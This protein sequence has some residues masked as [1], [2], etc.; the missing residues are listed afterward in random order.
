[1]RAIRVAS[2]ALVALV[3]LAG[4]VG[5]FL[6]RFDYARQDRDNISAAASAQHWLGTD[7]LGRD[8]FSRLL[9]GTRV[10][11]LLAPAAAALSILLALAIG[12]ATGWVGG[13]PER[14]SKT[15]IDLFL[16]VPWLFLLLMVRA[17]LPLNT[18]P[19]VSA[20]VTF[21]VLGA[22][23]WAAPGRILQAR[24]SRLRQ[25]QFILL[26]RAAGLSRWRLLY[27]HVA[28]NL[29]PVLLAQFWVSV[30]VFILAEANLS[31]LGLG[32]AEPLPSLGSMLRELESVL[33]L[34]GG[35]YRFAALM[36]L[37]VVVSSLQIAVSQQEAC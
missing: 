36:V 31:L 17:M 10:S 20:V 11:L 1:M 28:P 3:A 18:A 30:P 34:G 35:A 8:R 33:S 6:P 25:S 15:V 29:R 26:G 32:V 7:E 12:A 24:A 21:V 27:K 9:Q 4:I 22:L 5:G 16:S 19:L 37:V 14:V 2:I 13:I 23:G